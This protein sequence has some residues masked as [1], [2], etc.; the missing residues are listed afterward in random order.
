MSRPKPIAGILDI[1]PYVGGD[2]AAEGLAETIKLSSNEAATGASPKAIAAFREV[3]E[4]LHRYPDGGSNE[5]RGALAQMYG[6]AADG[7]ICG[8][9][10]D[11]IIAQMINAFCGPDCGCHPLVNA[12]ICIGLICFGPFIIGHW[13][14]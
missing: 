9:G 11:E 12:G 1:A 4:S 5:L 7:V 14:I 13:F 3:G 6:L 8:N 2:S 10:S